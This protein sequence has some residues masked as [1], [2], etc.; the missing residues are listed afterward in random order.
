ML[1]LLSIRLQ[2]F[3]CHATTVNASVENMKTSVSN[4]DSL[5]LCCSDSGKASFQQIA[6][7]GWSINYISSLCL[8]SSHPHS[9]FRMKNPLCLSLCF[10]L[11]SANVCWLLAPLSMSQPCRLSGLHIL[12][13]QHHCPGNPPLTPVWL[14][15]S[16]S[17]VKDFTGGSVAHPWLWGS[18]CLDARV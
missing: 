11:S 4:T 9:L 13:L 7:W 12:P 16:S 14:G 15:Q 17:A 2:A 3:L 5:I 1:S 8:F 6:T 10:Q 18:W